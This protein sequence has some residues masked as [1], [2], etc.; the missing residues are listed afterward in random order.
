[1]KKCTVLEDLVRDSELESD[2]VFLGNGHPDLAVL[3]FVNGLR[4]KQNGEVY[5][6]LHFEFVVEGA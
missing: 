1:M 3:V 2:V 5:S 4:F 6:G